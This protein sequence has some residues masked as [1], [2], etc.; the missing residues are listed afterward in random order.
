MREET[1][2]ATKLFIKSLFIS[3][4][5]EKELLSNPEDLRYYP[6]EERSLVF[7]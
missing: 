1:K 7:N 4:K 5:E 2:E 3:P 6:A